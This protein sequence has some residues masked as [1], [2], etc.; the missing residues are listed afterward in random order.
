[1]E[2]RYYDLPFGITTIDTGLV[3]P[4]FAASHLIVE[5]GQVAFV[6][7]GTSSTAP[8]LLEVLRRKQIPR[9]NVRYL[10]VTHVHLDHAGGAG[11]LLHDLPNAQ[12]VVHPQ[13]AR[14]L[15]SPSRL[16][17]GATALYGE[18]RMQTVFGNV[19]PVP[20]ERVIKVE[21]ESYLD[22]NGRQFLFL[23]SPG[24]ARHH[25][26]VVDERSQGIFSGDTFGSSYRK[27]DTPKGNFIFPATAP[28]QF[29]PDK[30]HA[31]IDQLMKYH[32]TSVYLAH[33]GQV[34][35][36]PRLADELHKCIDRFVE[37]AQG[38][39]AHGQERHKELMYNIKNLLVSRLKSHGCKLT[40]EEILTFLE[41]DLKLNVLGLE[42][43]LN[44]LQKHQKKENL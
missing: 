43:W 31:S 6:D 12:V 3:R 35:D 17:A 29:E 34:T 5:D 28:V 11:T 16:I 18:E 32:P 15:I 14:H 38:V 21:H 20:E 26:C 13:G 4:G 1:M 37:L 33:F 22:L 25:Y 7:V 27:F 19:V 36:V 8:I 9:E 30:M 41:P 10:M 40:R 39:E 42:V 24:H 44:R 2:A 23:D